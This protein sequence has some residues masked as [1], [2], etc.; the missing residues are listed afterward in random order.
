MLIEAAEGGARLKA[1][2]FETATSVFVKGDVSADSGSSLL[3]HKELTKVLAAAAA[4]ETKAAAARIPV[5]VEGA[6]VM[7]PD[8]AVP[9]E[10]YPSEEYPHVREAAPY[11]ATV[12]ACELFRQLARVLPAAG[13]DDTLPILQCVEMRVEE[14]VL[15][16]A[17]TDRYRFPV[18]EVATQDVGKCSAAKPGASA[19]F[20]AKTLQKLMQRL[21][22][23]EGQVL[24]GMADYLTL[25]FGDVEIS[26]GPT[27]SGLPQY[28]KLFPESYHAGITV[29]R[30]AITRATKKAAGILRAKGHQ[31]TPC[32]L[33]YG[34][35]GITVTPLLDPAER[36]RVKGM[37]APGTW[38]YGSL[39]SLGRDNN[40]FNPEFLL[41]TLSAF[42]GESITIHLIQN[43]EG[44]QF[45]PVLFTEES[46]PKSGTYRHLMMPVRLN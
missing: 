22:D 46:D 3:N 7:T 12:D 14:G 26:G 15:H 10:A 41:D 35:T 29:D 21:R 20:P 17:A 34:P 1:T 32:T 8:V 4:G 42:A 38:A 40:A 19:L 33:T 24:I 30:E 28:R 13:T 5:T 2:N 36:D 6:V 23:Y 27:E 31:N 37:Q 18:A 44:R 45:K 25:T 9:V 11:V 43:P 39:E 16:A